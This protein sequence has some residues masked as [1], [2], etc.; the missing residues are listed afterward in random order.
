MLHQCKRAR[1][2]VWMFFRVQELAE[3]HHCERARG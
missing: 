2:H 1:L 3:L